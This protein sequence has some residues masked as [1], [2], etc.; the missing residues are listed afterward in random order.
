VRWPFKQKSPGFGISKEFYLSVLCSRAVMPS[1]IELANPKAEGGAVEGFAVPLSD[2]AGQESLARPM[3]RGAFAVASKDRKSVLRLLVVSKED[4]GFDPEAILESRMAAGLG[5]ELLARLR[6]TWTL[7]QLT[8]ESHDPQ[9]YPTV[10]FAL[11]IAQRLAHLTEGVVADP[12]SQRYLLPE[13]VFHL[14]PQSEEVDARDVVQVHLREDPG[15][16]LHAYTLGLRKFAMPEFEITGLAPN[17]EADAGR[18]LYAAA[19]AVLVQGPV[20]PGR[21]M[22]AD[23]LPFEVAQGGLERSVW[24]ETPC[25]ELLPPTGSTS[26]EAL[27]AWLVETGQPS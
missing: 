6:A 18:F 13:A 1:A 24:G 12:L 27:G 8:F 4:A 7:A 22:G 5:P 11:R 20:E 26:T 2:S 21:H 3:E 9:V 16:G 10:R 25:F 23:R 15:E 19:Q 17:T 14:P